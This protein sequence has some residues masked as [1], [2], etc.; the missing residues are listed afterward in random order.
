MAILEEA[1]LYSS[2]S[3]SLAAVMMKQKKKEKGQ[4]HYCTYPTVE[5]AFPV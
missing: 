5:V 2:D 3:L 1:V 4:Y